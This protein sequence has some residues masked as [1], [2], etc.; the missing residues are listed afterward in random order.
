MPFIEYPSRDGKK[1]IQAHI[2][3]GDDGDCILMGCRTRAAEQPSPPGHIHQSGSASALQ[4]EVKPTPPPAAADKDDSFTLAKANKFLRAWAGMMRFGTVSEDVYAY[5]RGICEGVEGKNVACPH[6][7]DNGLGEKYCNQCGCGNR[8][9][10]TL[11]VEGAP[12]G[13]TERLWMPDPQCPTLAIRPA[14]GIGNLKSVGGRLRQ[15]KKLLMAGKDELR[16]QKVKTGEGDKFL[17]E[18]EGVSDGDNHMA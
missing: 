2:E 16:K 1:V 9:Y 4:D 18:L 10:A 12:I 8:K 11:Y 13:D 7:A 5:R 15:M 6:L 3:E 14:K 17:A